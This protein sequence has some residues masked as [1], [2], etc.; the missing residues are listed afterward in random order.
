MRSAKDISLFGKESDYSAVAL[1]TEQRNL[2]R[3][4]REVGGSIRQQESAVDSGK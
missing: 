1:L 4:P 2:V 3:T